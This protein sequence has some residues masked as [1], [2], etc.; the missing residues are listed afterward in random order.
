MYTRQESRTLCTFE[1]MG[2]RFE[3]RGA[4]FGEPKHPAAYQR[5]NMVITMYMRQLGYLVTTYVDDSFVVIN[6]D[7]LEKH[8]NVPLAPYL[9][10]LLK[11]SFGLFIN[12]K[13]S[14]LSV[15]KEKEFLGMVINSEHQ[16]VSIPDDK[17]YKF[18]I[19]CRQ[20]HSQTFIKFKELE[21]LRGKAI[22]FLLVV[23]RAKVNLVVK[24]TKLILI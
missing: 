11:V 19:H 15:N 2:K 14:D 6:D 1:W 13:K 4:N 7:I 24:T 12:I 17:W 23:H 3:Y 20:F 5:M 21:K 22:S 8:N 9:L 16:T 10:V 18:H